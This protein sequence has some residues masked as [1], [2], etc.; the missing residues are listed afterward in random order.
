M[1]LCC[2]CGALTCIASNRWPHEFLPRLTHGAPPTFSRSH[3]ASV[4]LASSLCTPR[5]LR[6]K[7]FSHGGLNLS[8]HSSLCSMIAPL[9]ASLGSVN[10]YSTTSTVT[11]MLCWQSMAI[12]CTHIVSF[13]WLC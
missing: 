13:D 3:T 5:N 10:T 8:R 7:W 2:L 6:R 1:T 9:R 11:S 12:A 4:A